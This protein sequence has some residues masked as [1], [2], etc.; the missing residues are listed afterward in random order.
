MKTVAVRTLDAD[1]FRP[2][3]SFANLINPKTVPIQ[4]G[5]VRP[6]DAPRFGIG[7]TKEW[8]ERA[9]V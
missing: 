4:D 1:A 7:V 9:A 3:G 6:T 2:Y 8:L 5:Y